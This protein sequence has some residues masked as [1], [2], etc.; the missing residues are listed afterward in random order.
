M[1]PINNPNI[2]PLCV[3]YD[4]FSKEDLKNI[5]NCTGDNE[6]QPAKINDFDEQKV[7]KKLKGKLDKKHRNCDVKIISL[8]EKT[9]WIYEKIID[10]INFIN[11]K[12]YNMILKFI[13]PLNFLKYSYNEFEDD[14]GYYHIHVDDDGLYS[15][16]NYLII[17]KLT[18]VVQLS[19]PQDYEGGKLFLYYNQEKHESPN[20]F[21]SIIIFPSRIAH[22]V[23][24]ITKGN[25]YS[26]VGWIVGPNIL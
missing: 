4:F 1:Y 16:H 19:E 22:E 13:E 9:N 8:N 17:R 23:T 24:P 3:S 12:N 26:L 25:R 5:F 6:F 21:G 2:D 15:S 20:E 18:F 11:Y 14:S 10:K 7:T